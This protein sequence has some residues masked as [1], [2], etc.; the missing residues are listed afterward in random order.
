MTRSTATYGFR[1]WD[2]TGRLIR[3][4]AGRMWIITA[5]PGSVPIRGA[6]RRITTDAG[7]AGPM[8][9]VG[10]RVRLGPVRI[11]GARRWSASSDGAGEWEW[12]SDSVLVS[13]TW[14]G[15]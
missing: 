5:G 15:C 9:G 12:A 14:A 7:S 3:P 2:R 1:P 4:A 13:A 11:I 10:G 6:G 8:A